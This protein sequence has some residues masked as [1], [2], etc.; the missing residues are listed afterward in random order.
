MS[1]GSTSLVDR[2]RAEVALL[3]PDDRLPSSRELMARHQVGP[4]TVSR[5][6]AAL[7][8]EGLVVTRPGSGT[9]VAP[10][11]PGRAEP[12]DTGW[13]SL[14]LGERT[15]DAGALADS[16][17]DAPDGTIMLD[18]GYLHRELQ[19][20]KA[21][22]AAAVRAA[23]R[24]DA[25]DRASGNGLAA[26]RSAFATMTGAAQQHVMI[27]SGGQ[28]GLSTAFRAIAAPGSP[29]LVESP[30][31]YGALAAAR[32]AGLR[33]VPIPLDADGVRP[34]LLAEAF[35]TTGAKLFY[36]Q[37]A[38][39]NPT[40]AVLAADRRPAVLA[41]A[42]AAGAFVVEDDVHRHL[43]HGPATPPPLLADD[44]DGTVVHLTALTKSAAPSMRIGAIVAQGPVLE[45]LR[46][47]RHVDDFF[48]SRP[49]QETALELLGSPAWERH[50]RGLSAELR[51]R[52]Q[53]LVSAL[54]TELP[55][56]SVDRVPHGGFHLWVRLPSGVD[57]VRFAAT[58]RRNG[59]AVGAG[60]RYF[61]AERPGPYL[62]LNFAAT[63]DRAELVE[64]VRR[65]ATLATDP[66]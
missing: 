6:V 2:L 41:A 65:L 5:A 38:H 29:I 8:A 56:W 17:A 48:V 37:P 44:R 58:A 51:A 30:T 40:G 54:R 53:T 18:G 21:L 9:F 45:R 43:G 49:Q 57:E 63:G 64:A 35:A 50:L 15:I 13:Q 20:T 32:A 11:R 4:G 33:I 47:L 27:T 22:T 1:D 60:S 14:A 42:R 23:R 66:E 19:P 46:A 26:L 16:P 3:A 55:E 10:H 12:A 61:P 52:C 7:A 34:D 62:R 59:V 24:P 36:C 25:W 28:N 39:H 31:Y